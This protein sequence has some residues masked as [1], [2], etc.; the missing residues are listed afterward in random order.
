[1]ALAR[2]SRVRSTQPAPTQRRPPAAASRASLNDSP[3]DG[4]AGRSDGLERHDRGRPRQAGVRIRPCWVHRRGRCLNLIRPCAAR[5]RAR[6]I[7][8]AVRKS[9]ANTHPI[10]ARR[11]P[12]G[13]DNQLVVLRRRDAS[14]LQRG[15]GRAVC[16]GVL[17]LWQRSTRASPPRHHNGRIV[18]ARASGQ[19]ERVPASHR[20]VLGVINAYV[21]V[22]VGVVLNRCPR[23]GLTVANRAPSPTGRNTIAGGHGD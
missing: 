6:P 17:V 18:S 13:R 16:P 7:G 15:A 2:C 19:L 8:V 23:V 20:W 4:S 14:R 22:T 1:M 21:S 5:R 9:G 11:I 3:P 10:G 12:D